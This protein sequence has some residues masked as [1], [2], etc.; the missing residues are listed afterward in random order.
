MELLKDYEINFRY[1]LGRVN[2]IADTLSCKPYLTLNSLWVL[3]R[4]LGKEFKKLE[5]NVVT[6]GIRPMLYTIEVQSTLIKEIRDAQD[7]DLWLDRIR[8]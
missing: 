5:I 3:S 1:Q 4:E 2:V 7:T 8:P 6:R